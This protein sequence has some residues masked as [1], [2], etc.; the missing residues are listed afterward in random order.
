VIACEIAKQLRMMGKKVIMMAMFDAYAHSTEKTLNKDL[1]GLSLKKVNKFLLRLSHNITQLIKDP[2]TW[3]EKM[4]QVQRKLPKWI[5]RSNIVKLRKDN[6]VDFYSNELSKIYFNAAVQKY[7]LSNYEDTIELFRATKNIY[8]YMDDPI[9]LGWH[10][11]AKTVNL[12]RVKGTHTTMLQ[13]PNDLHFAEVLQQ[14][15]D[16][17][18]QLFKEE[19]IMKEAAL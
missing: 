5:K 4:I 14:C 17:A 12:H 9:Y 15:L 6:D 8:Y 7:K 10:R 19:S 1:M 2:Q 16:N 13:P 11:Y 3:N 18:N